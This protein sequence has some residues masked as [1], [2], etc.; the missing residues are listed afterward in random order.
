MFAGHFCP[1]DPDPDRVQGPTRSGSGF[2]TLLVTCVPAPVSH[3]AAEV[4]AI[5]RFKEGVLLLPPGEPGP[6]QHLW[7]L[8]RLRLREHH[9]K[10]LLERSKSSKLWKLRPRTGVWNSNKKFVYSFFRHVTAETNL[11]DAGSSYPKEEQETKPFNSNRYYFHSQ[12]RYRIH[13]GPVHFGCTSHA[14]IGPF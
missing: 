1:L 8:V 2:S 13:L 11:A 14:K 5:Q 10:R 6:L 12:C 4:A 9:T 7:Q 3:A